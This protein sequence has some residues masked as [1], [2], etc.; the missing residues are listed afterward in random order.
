MNNRFYL[1][2]LINFKGISVNFRLH[3]TTIKN[4]TS[5]LGFETVSKKKKLSVHSFPKLSSGKKKKTNEKVKG[6]SNF[7][8]IN[9]WDFESTLFLCASAQTTVIGITRTKIRIFF[10]K[11]YLRLCFLKSN[12]RSWYPS[13]EYN[14]NRINFLGL[15]RKIKYLTVS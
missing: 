9:K 1:W 6:I 5:S 13:I 8:E 15:H 11:W 10:K 3:S 14:K 4:K 7:R 12:L 2:K